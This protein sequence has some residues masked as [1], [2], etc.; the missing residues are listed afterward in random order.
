MKILL[1]MIIIIININEIIFLLKIH[2]FTSK[3]L[4]N[5]VTYWIN[6]LILT[7]INVLL[8]VFMILT[9]VAASLSRIFIFYS[10]YCIYL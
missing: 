6:M 7:I 5:L 8:L 10:F 1:L 3:F 4:V 9:E 2:L